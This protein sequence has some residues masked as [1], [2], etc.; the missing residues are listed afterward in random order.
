MTSFLQP[1]GNV[2]FI[3]DDEHDR[4]GFM[5]VHDKNKDTKPPRVMYANPENGSSNHSTLSRLGVSFSD[6]I[7]LRS[8]NTTTFSLREMPSGTVINGYFGINHTIV[9]F[10]PIGTLKPNTNY[11]LHLPAGGITDLVGNGLDK[12]YVF[13]FSTGTAGSTGSGGQVI[14]DGSGNNSSVG[15][16]SGGSTSSS[17]NVGNPGSPWM[18]E[19][20]KM[21]FTGGVTASTE[22]TG[23]SGSGYADFPA[24]GGELKGTLSQVMLGQNQISIVYAKRRYRRSNAQC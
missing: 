6:Q 18:A 16:S 8:V 17:G 2:L 10:A 24:S 20:E 22:N 7:D 1:I 19:A 12:A 3:S 13:K 5:A 15:T 14:V 11:E 4:G 21:T 23:Y 9:H